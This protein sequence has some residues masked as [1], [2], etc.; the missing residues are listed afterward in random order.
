MHDDDRLAGYSRPDLIRYVLRT[1]VGIPDEKMHM[2]DEMKAWC[3][4]NVGEERPG[5]ILFEAMEGWLDYFDGEWSHFP[6]EIEQGAYLF[7][8]DR[9]QDRVLF[10]LTWL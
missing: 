8:F 4:A 7:W 10:T 2:L 1:C 5:S 3:N 9:K 6:N